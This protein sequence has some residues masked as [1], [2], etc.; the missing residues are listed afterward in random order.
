MQN[1]I[2][3]YSDTIL[4]TL[5]AVEYRADSSPSHLI[6]S[7]RAAGEGSPAVRHS[8]DAISGPGADEIEYSAERVELPSHWHLPGAA[9]SRI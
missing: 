5:W 4:P 9:T 3:T 8:A 1:I 6:G 2:I 7:W